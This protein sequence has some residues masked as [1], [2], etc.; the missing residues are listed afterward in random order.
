MVLQPRGVAYSLISFI[1]A[2]KRI[3]AS[4]CC[5]KEADCPAQ[6]DVKSGLETAV[7]G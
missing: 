5:N 1:N 4:L 6:K 3:L 2:A 7:G